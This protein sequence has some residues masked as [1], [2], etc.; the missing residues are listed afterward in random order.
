MGIVGLGLRQ[1][2]QTDFSRNWSGSFKVW[3]WRRYSLGSDPRKGG[4][5]LV[6]NKISEE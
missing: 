3:F 4:R 2:L 1:A 5:D 6:E